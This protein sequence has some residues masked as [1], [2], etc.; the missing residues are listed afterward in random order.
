MT[1]ILHE[2]I[3][4]TFEALFLVDVRGLLPRQV[5]QEVRIE[6][7]VHLHADGVRGLLVDNV[8]FP[9]TLFMRFLLAGPRLYG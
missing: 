8:S 3:H 1:G 4:R 9:Q 6:V 2:H 5:H 7:K